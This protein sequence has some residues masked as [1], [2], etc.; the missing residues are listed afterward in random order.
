R[1]SAPGPGGASEPLHAVA[2]PRVRSARLRLLR[3]KGS[4]AM[5]DRAAIVTRASRGIG[6]ALAQTLGEEGYGLTLTARKP[7]TLERAAEEL[8][9]KGYDVD[10]HAANMADDEASHA[11]V[12]RHRE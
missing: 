1:A 12:S 2:R 4:A 6:H 11:V 3:S 9:A 8:R 7:D 5:S 10:H